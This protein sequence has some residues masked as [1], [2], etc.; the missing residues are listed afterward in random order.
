MKFFQK[1][2]NFLVGRKLRKKP[3]EQEIMLGEAIMND[4]IGRSRLS[5]DP[6]EFDWLL[7][8]PE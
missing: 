5:D 8:P 6:Y 7:R 3:T 1:L 4:R 2:L